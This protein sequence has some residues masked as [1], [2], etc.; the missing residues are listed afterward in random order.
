[1]TNCFHS[2]FNWA[3]FHRLSMI[4]WLLLKSMIKQI[5]SCCIHQ[6]AQGCAVQVAQCG[7]GHKELWK[8]IAD[9]ESKAL[10][11]CSI[12]WLHSTGQFYTFHTLLLTENSQTGWQHSFTTHYTDQCSSSLK[13]THKTP[14]TTTTTKQKKNNNIVSKEPPTHNVVTVVELL[15]AGDTSCDE[16]FGEIGHQHPLHTPVAL[17]THTVAK[18][19]GVTIARQCFLGRWLL[20][21][22]IHK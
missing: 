5:T 19:V 3:F 11:I 15:G 21:G 13:K 6:L 22:C 12:W 1:M 7:T 17:T 14:T 16:G 2:N 18:V 4:C 10:M 20:W 9:W 8:D